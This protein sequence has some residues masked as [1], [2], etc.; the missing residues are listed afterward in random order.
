MKLVSIQLLP[1]SE[2]EFPEVFPVVKQALY[3]HVDSV[4]GWDDQFQQH[5][6]FTDY[7][8]DWFHWVV[9]N[10][11]KIGLVC[12]KP[13]DTAYH[14]HLLILFPQYQ[15][16]GFGQVVMQQITTLTKSEGRNKIT[17]SSFTR[18]TKAIQ[19]YTRLGYQVTEEDECF[20]SM[21][22][23]LEQQKMDY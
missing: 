19:F 22:L 2:Q 7:Q 17:L 18:N 6:L 12:F 16:Q 21:T 11:N 3:E 8:P 9:S 13:Y 5:R 20:V 14:I 15:N 10:Q 1:I 4:F 23:D